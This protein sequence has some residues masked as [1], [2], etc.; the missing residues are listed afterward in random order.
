MKRRTF[1]QAAGMAVT[2][3]VVIRSSD[4]KKHEIKRSSAP[5]PRRL[6]KPGVELSCA[7]LGGMTLLGMTEANVKA[8]VNEAL[9]RG[10]NYFDVSP[11]Y[12][13]GEA[14]MKMGKA[15]EPLRPN[16][17]LAGK[18]LQRSGE[19]AQRELEE[20]LRRLRTDHFD[21][22]QLHAVSRPEDVEQV[23]AAGG[24]LEAL[25][26]ARE[27]GQVRFLGFSAHAEEAALQLLERFPFDSVLFPINLFCFRRGKFGPRL[28]AKAK[29]KGVTLL[30]LKALAF[31][32]WYTG[33]ARLYPNCWYKP[34]DDPAMALK[35]L[36]FTLSQGVT[37][38]IPPG[39][40]Q[41]FR[42]A[43]DLLP[44]APPMEEAE[45]N[46]LFQ[47]IG[48]ITPIFKNPEVK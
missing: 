30:A 28:A 2:S 38:L 41:L 43:L 8:L 15:V 31:R 45:Q 48:A 36:R 10:V 16:I 25:I 26:Q 5:L 7:G 20:S 35:A 13:N 3:S 22:Y 39:D 23:L 32:P 17:F 40:Q 24:A 6:Y 14:E 18:T 4:Q 34:I 12:G 44:D 29:E 1:L 19:G 47:G 11:S 37:A 21:L 46:I 9:A 42:L 27:K 33:D